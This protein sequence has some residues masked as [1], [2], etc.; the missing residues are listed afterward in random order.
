[1]V[2][3]CRTLVIIAVPLQSLYDARVGLQT[4]LTQIIQVVNHVIVTL[5]THAGQT[6]LQHTSGSCLEATSGITTSGSGLR[7]SVQTDTH[8]RSSSYNTSRPK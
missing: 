8:S 7:G 2:E 5:E 4:S 3:G 1:M 6:Q